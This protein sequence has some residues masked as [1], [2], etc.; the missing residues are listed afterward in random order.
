MRPA[1][2]RLQARTTILPGLESGTGTVICRPKKGCPPS[3][4]STVPT[5]ANLQ[6]SAPIALLSD[7]PTPTR[8]E[9]PPRT[10]A[11]S[12]ELYDQFTY[13][14]VHGGLRST[15]DNVAICACTP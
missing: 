1:A 5:G 4:E 10:Y 2:S 13:K 12:G 3:I 9:S 14:T 7:P 15:S 8:S 11:P 6:K